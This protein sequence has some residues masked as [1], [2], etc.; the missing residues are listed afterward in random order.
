[1]ASVQNP[2][3]ALLGA[4]ERVQEPKKAKAKKKP[5]QQPAQAATLVEHGALDRSG[6]IPLR[7]AFPVPAQAAY[8]PSEPLTLATAIAERERDA[9]NAK[10][11]SQK[12]AMWKEWMRQVTPAFC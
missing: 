2:F 5:A 12:T 4:G 3:D 8:G 1:M 6:P 9:H 10:S 7:D 11:S